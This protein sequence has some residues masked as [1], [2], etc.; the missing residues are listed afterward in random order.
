MTKLFFEGREIT[1]DELPE[2]PGVMGFA[3]EEHPGARVGLTVRYVESWPR[4]FLV[5]D[6]YQSPF[7]ERATLYVIERIAGGTLIG[8]KVSYET[9]KRP[10]IAGK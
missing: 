8:R 5:D 2:A 7:Y 4:P 9:G 10:N 3:A 1:P 6:V